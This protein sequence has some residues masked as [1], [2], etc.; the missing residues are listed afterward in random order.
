MK[1]K[2]SLLLLS[3]VFLCIVMYGQKYEIPEITKTIKGQKIFGSELEYILPDTVN[4]ILKKYINQLNDTS[5]TFYM[6]IIFN[7][8]FYELRLYSR[9]RCD[10]ADSTSI[11][12]QLLASTNRFCR[13]D[14]MYIPI[15]FEIDKVFGSYKFTMT[16]T[17]LVIKL[18]RKDYRQFDVSSVYVTN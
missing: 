3:C 9:K 8:S 18:I 17:A 10:L 14:D 5:L 6:E 1:I 16:A 4:Q 2:R 7:K 11:S 13:I 12:T 15:Y